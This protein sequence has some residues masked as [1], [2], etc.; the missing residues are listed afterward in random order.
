MVRTDISRIN[1]EEKY[2][3]NERGEKVYSKDFAFCI[4]LI[5]ENGVGAIPCSVFYSD[6]FKHLGNNL[7]RFAFCKTDEVV[8]EAKEKLS[9]W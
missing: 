7:V 5:R 2:F 9:R 1:V 8:K 4:K 3:L 6:E